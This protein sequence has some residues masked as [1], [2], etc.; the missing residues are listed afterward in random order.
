MRVVTGIA[1]GVAAIWV[2]LMVT[3]TMFIAQ[4]IFAIAFLTAVAATAVVMS[5][6]GRAASRR[7]SSAQRPGTSAVTAPRGP[8]SVPTPR[9]GASGMSSAVVRRPVPRSLPQSDGWSGQ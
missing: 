9:W 6:R 2:F 4:H 1:I 7:R 8:V 3:V 5:R